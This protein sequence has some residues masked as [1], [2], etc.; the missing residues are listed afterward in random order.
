MQV[1]N[2]CLWIG[3]LALCLWLAW[4][5][6]GKIDESSIKGDATQNLKITHNLLVH[7]EFALTKAGEHWMSTNFREPV[8]PAVTA[9]Y[10]RL[11]LPGVLHSDLASWHQGDNAKNIKKVNAFWVFWGLLATLELALKVLRRRMLALATLAVSYWLFFGTSGVVNTLYTELPAATLML[12]ATWSFASAIESRQWSKTRAIVS[13][14]LMGAL[15]LTKTVFLVGIPVFLMLIAWSR[16]RPEEATVS[17]NRISQAAA[18]AVLALLSFGA[19]ISPWMIRNKLQLDTFEI[20][21]GRTGY[22]TLYRAYMDLM[23][24]EEYRLGFSLYG[25]GLYRQ[26]VKGTSLE[27]LPQDRKRGGRVQ[28]LNY[29]AIDFRDED[30]S[31]VFTRRPDLSLTFYTLPAAEYQVLLQQMRVEGVSRPELAADK[32][33]KAKAMDIFKKHPIKHLKVGILVFWSEFWIFTEHSLED[34]W[35]ITAW[36]HTGLTLLNAMAGICLLAGFL[37]AIVRRDRRWAFVTGLPVT[38][39]LLHGLLTQGLPRLNVPV[40]PYMVLAFF[41]ALDGWKANPG[42]GSRTAPDSIEPA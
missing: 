36:G 6:L 5:S 33:L 19:V 23:T 42:P 14:A 3:K 34:V 11:A 4:A 13:G 40:I 8:P 37:I 20:S 24:D 35:P 7:G 26:L 21:S 16:P 38:L 22:V 32:V 28:R 30:R 27:L 2:I 31:S 9:L 29:G 25:P 41:A 39:M 18:L 15:C 10:I 1:R 17:S 12:M